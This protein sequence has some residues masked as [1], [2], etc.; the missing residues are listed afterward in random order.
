MFSKLQGYLKI[1]SCN[2]GVFLFVFF[3]LFVVVFFF[4]VILK[5]NIVLEII[6][7]AVVKNYIYIKKKCC[8]IISVIQSVAYIWLKWGPCALFM[9]YTLKHQ[10]QVLSI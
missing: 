10:V 3:C 9:S 7:H 6:L 1:F 5:E 2:R 4:L 8:F